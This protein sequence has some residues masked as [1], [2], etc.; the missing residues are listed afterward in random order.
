MGDQSQLAA[1]MIEAENREALKSAETVEEKLRVAFKG[2]RDH[3][4]FTDENDQLMGGIGAAMFSMTKEDKERVTE[5][6][7]VFQSLNAAI[8]GVPVD[9]S[10]IEIMANPIGIRKLW[11]EK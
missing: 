9:F 8:S 5:E 1:S 11:L 4:M 7:R 6:L 2:A 10:A 3:W